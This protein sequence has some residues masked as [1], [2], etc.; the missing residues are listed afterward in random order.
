VKSFL[1][2]NDMVNSLYDEFIGLTEKYYR[3]RYI[4][5]MFHQRFRVLLKF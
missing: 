1:K 3:I 2:F 5:D 4:L